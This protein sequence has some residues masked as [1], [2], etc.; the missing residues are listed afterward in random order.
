MALPGGT[1]FET[2]P[3]TGCNWNDGTAEPKPSSG[4]NRAHYREVYFE[5]LFAAFGCVGETRS[6]LQ[7]S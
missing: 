1:R 6:Y 5:W 3:K 7:S 2:A 4:S